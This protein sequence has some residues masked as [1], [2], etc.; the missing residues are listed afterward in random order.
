MTLVQ[1]AAWCAATFVIAAMVVLPPLVRS[2]TVGG[3]NTFSAGETASAAEVNQNFSAVE[4]AVDGND[5]LIA[6]L[7]SRVA[8]VEATDPV[9][10]PQGEQGQ[11]VIPV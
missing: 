4:S 9:P 5:G 6:A 2:D 11:K 10:G 1:K 7:E 3:L 8:A